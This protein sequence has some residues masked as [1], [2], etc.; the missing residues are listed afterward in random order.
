[1]SKIPLK[2][3]K[4]GNISIRIFAQDALAQNALKAFIFFNSVP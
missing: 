1:M 3:D 4:S 2:M